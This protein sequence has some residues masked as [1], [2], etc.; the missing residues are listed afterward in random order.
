MVV[1][2]LIAGVWTIGLFWF[3]KWN[4]S[5]LRQVPA[6]SWATVGLVWTYA[7]TVTMLTLLLLVALAIIL[8]LV[9]CALK[10]SRC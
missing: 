4:L 7:W 6:L 10:C 9:E 2:F 1:C 3:T 8:S 5:M